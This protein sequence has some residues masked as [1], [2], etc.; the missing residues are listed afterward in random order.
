MSATPDEPSS[1]PDLET[2]PPTEDPEH[3]PEVPEDTSALS[4]LPT[5]DLRPAPAGDPD[6]LPQL[7]CDGPESAPWSDGQ[8][9][10]LDLIDEF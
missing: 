4:N 10:H 9:I 3:A 8:P 2:V 7:A 6:W 5:P 1:D